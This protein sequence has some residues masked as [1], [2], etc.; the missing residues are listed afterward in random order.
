MDKSERPI[1]ELHRL[2]FFLRMHFNRVTLYVE[3]QFI[4]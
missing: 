3:K 1:G 2:A 4:L